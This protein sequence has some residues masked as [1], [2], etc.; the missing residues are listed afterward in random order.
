MII[1]LP[2]RIMANASNT[3]ANISPARYDDIMNTWGGMDWNRTDLPNWGSALW[4]IANL[5]PDVVGPIAWFILFAIPFLM[6]WITHTDMLPAAVVGIFMGLY[7]IGF[8]GSQY[9]GA[10]IAMIAIAITGVIFSV[11]IRRL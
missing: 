1:E 6:M 4:N 11:W 5:Y 7:I 3:I 10:G 2:S 8:V 9:F